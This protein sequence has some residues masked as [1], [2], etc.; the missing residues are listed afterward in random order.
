MEE[1]LLPKFSLLFT[2]YVTWRVGSGTTCL[3]LFSGQI[4]MSFG[5]F[6]IFCLSVCLFFLFAFFPYSY[7]GMVW[8]ISSLHIKCQSCLWA[9]HLMMS[10]V[11]RKRKCM[12]FTGSLIVNTLMPSR[13]YAWLDMT[14]QYHFI[15]MFCMFPT[16]YY[17]RR[18]TPV[19]TVLWK[20]VRFFTINILLIVKK[21]SKLKSNQYR[22][23]MTRKPRKL[24]GLRQLTAKSKKSPRGVY[25]EL[26]WKLLPSA[27][28]SVIIYPTSVPAIVDIKTFH[29]NNKHAEKSSS[30]PIYMYMY[31]CNFLDCFLDSIM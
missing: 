6:V 9:V 7:L 30:M 28:K 22:V 31:G 2:L 1:T 19:S 15:H 17:G 3:L 11:E 25:P 4:C 27:G 29:W 14:V 16:L 10:Q 26:P 18:S 23:W 24:K 13:R 5:L 20:S 8:K 21:I 12:S